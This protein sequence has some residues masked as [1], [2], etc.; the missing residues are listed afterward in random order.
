MISKYNTTIICLTDSEGN[1][2]NTQQTINVEYE[3]WLKAGIANY[4]KQ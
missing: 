4:K 3:T 1:S 2:F